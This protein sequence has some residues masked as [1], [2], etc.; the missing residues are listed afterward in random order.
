MSSAFQLSG[1][2]C[3]IGL[4]P[5]ASPLTHIG[6][7][8]EK[9]RQG[10]PGA[11]ARS[12]VA[13]LL[14]AGYPPIGFLPQVKRRL[15][16][17]TDHQY[18]AESSGPTRGRGRHPGKGTHRAQARAGLLTGPR[19]GMWTD[20]HA[21]KLSSGLSGLGLSQAS[22]GPKGQ[23]EWLPGMASP[24]PRGGEFPGRKR[25]AVVGRQQPQGLPAWPHQRKEPSAYPTPILLPC[26]AREAS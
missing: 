8:V 5:L 10:G 20:K 19:L 11:S 13:S 4:C 22:R 17:E 15:D 14:V 16:L 21:S 9:L 26:I 25:N 2:S 23:L 18:L 3:V 12:L 24:G 1:L 7:L 6:I